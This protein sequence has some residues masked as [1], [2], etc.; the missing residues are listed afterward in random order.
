MKAEKITPSAWNKPAEPWKDPAIAVL[1][2]LVLDRQRA[3]QKPVAPV[4][5]VEKV[6]APAPAV[7][8]S[9]AY[10]HVAHCAAIVGVDATKIFELS[11]SGTLSRN[12][13]LVE[14]R[15]RLWLC[16]AKT[17]T[18]TGLRMSVS[19]IARRTGVNSSTIFS[20][21]EANRIKRDTT[22][23][24]VLVESRRV[25]RTRVGARPLGWMMAGNQ[26]IREMAEA[27]GASLG[28]IVGPKAR[29]R[30]FWCQVRQRI[31][32]KL[33]DSGYAMQECDELFCRPE[34]WCET[35]VRNG[36]AGAFHIGNKPT[37]KAG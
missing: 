29:N 19:E 32:N 24:N 14:A 25:R 33:L 2:S 7:V 26:I 8:A 21:F 17:L 16:M 15:I 3:E 10:D 36:Q 6:E 22:T 18:P 27:E 20:S 31:V 30:G 13:L 1:Q 5:K 9:P 23:D 4:K 34:R 12:P 11:P 35:L 28:S 37:N